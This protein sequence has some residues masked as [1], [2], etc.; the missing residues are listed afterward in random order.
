MSRLWVRIFE[1][2][3]ALAVDVLATAALVYRSI[4]VGSGIGPVY[5]RPRFSG[6]LDDLPG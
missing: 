4:R 2:L 5:V 3:A 1:L 6:G